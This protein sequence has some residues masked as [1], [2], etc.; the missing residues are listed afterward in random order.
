[1]CKKT[2]ETNRL[3][4]AGV[5]NARR[6]KSQVPGKIVS[7]EWALA[8]VFPRRNGSGGTISRDEGTGSWLFSVGT[9]FHKDGF[10]NGSE[11]RLLQRYMETDPVGFARELEGFFVVVVGDARSSET[12]VVTD[13]VG[14]CHCFL[15]SFENCVVLSGSSLLLA[16]IGG[17]RLDP[18]GCQEF[19]AT[20]IVYEDRTVFREV[21]KLAPATVFRFG[22]GRQNI[23]HCYWKISDL[24]PASLKDDTAV[25]MVW[26]ELKNGLKRVGSTFPRV[27]C[28]LTGGYDSRVI[29]GALSK[30]GV[31]FAATVSGP[32]DSHD[33]TLSRKLARIMELEHLH[34]PPAGSLSFE[35]IRKAAEFCDGEYDLLEYAGILNVHERLSQRFDISLNGSFGEVARGYWW[36]LL[37]PRICAREKLDAM[38]LARS[39]FAAQAHDPLL[40]DPEIRVD[41][42][43]HF[44]GVIERTNSGLDRLPNTMQ[45]DHVYL[46]MRMQR[47]QG[48][49]ASSTNQLWPCLSPFLFRKV[50]EAM[51]QSKAL[52]RWRSLMPR[53]MLGKYHPRVAEVPLE[54]G[55]P[56]MP[57]NWKNFYRFWPVAPMFG[58]KIISKALRYAGHR[59]ATAD[60]SVIPAR[61]RLWQEPGVRDLLDPGMM[62]TGGLF[63]KGKLHG[64]LERS[65]DLSFPYNDQW[66]RILS[67]EYGLR[68]LEET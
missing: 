44:A 19:L 36:E 49:I 3:F 33:V 45:M 30:A 13:L 61:I 15:R 32:P 9:W 67:L 38:Q 41:M 28:D 57:A 50:L 47:W 59:K 8:A 27:V 10:G 16:S 21:R 18:L 34:V 58:K 56:A 6:L 52:L 12:I 4:H 7:E 2:E 1:M 63:D 54:N 55:Y 25:E 24:T 23:M 37:F 29:A 17:Y 26:E 60:P 5:E 42:V 48:R 51:L 43:P 68:R 62:K 53:R 31:K 11:S 40:I 65:R 35:Q 20:G 66:Q 39:R 22:N 46:M 14:S 64:F